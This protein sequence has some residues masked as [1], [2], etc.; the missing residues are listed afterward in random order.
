M[1]NLSYLLKSRKFWIA[2]F[3]I[4]G[5]VLTSFG[6]EE[7]PVEQVADIAMVLIAAIAIED[8]ARNLAK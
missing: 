3:T 1:T 2:I 8:A 4:V 7:F 6:I 5:L